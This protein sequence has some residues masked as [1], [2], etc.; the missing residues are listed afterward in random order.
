MFEVERGSDAG[1]NVKVE[2]ARR[3]HVRQEKVHVGIIRRARG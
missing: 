3:A 2:E 1:R